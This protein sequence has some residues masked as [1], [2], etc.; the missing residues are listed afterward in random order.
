M[1]SVVT[2]IA[3]SVF[4][5]LSVSHTHKNYKTDEQIEVSFGKWT[6]VGPRYYVLDGG[7][8]PHSGK[9]EFWMHLL[10]HCKV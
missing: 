7:P 1:L 5:C 6:Q 8:D 4:V 3:W 2:D 9:G 10:A